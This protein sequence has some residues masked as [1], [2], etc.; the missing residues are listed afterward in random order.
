M[1]KSVD[2]GLS[3]VFIFA[4]HTMELLPLFTSFRSQLWPLCRDYRETAFDRGVLP[5]P[6]T[7]DVTSDQARSTNQKCQ[8]K[9]CSNAHD[10]TVI[11]GG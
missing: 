10:F 7:W 4:S 9:D 2:V 1:V 5:R 8:A 11:N 6:Y 3:T